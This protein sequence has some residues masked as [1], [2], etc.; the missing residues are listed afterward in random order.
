MPFVP[1]TVGLLPA[2]AAARSMA[3]ISRLRATFC[4]GLAMFR[5][6]RLLVLL[7]LLAFTAACDAGDGHDKVLGSVHVAAGQSPS[8]AST[9]NGAIRIDPNA[10]SG[11]DSTV[12]G[13][14]ELGDNASADTLSTVNGSIT[15]GAHASVQA[16][17]TV[18]GS[19][20]LGNGAR[21]T[22]DIES[23]NG[24]LSLS[25]GAD[26]AGRATNVN[27]HIS[28]D[29]AHVGGGIE[30]SNGDIDITGA[31]RVDG[32]ILVRKTNNNG[33]FHFGI[34]RTTH[35]VIGPGATVNGTLK[36]E[37]EVKLYV[38]DRAHVGPIVGA[39]PVKFS[40]DQP[41]ST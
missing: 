32:G 29:G 30:T 36:F 33:W 9:V 27:G 14:I 28:I 23:V 2:R 5:Y 12:N 24:G 1:V 7:P 26:V 41:P 10:K 15:L 37:R 20:R 38:S 17:S 13:S 3:S 21:I 25:Q 4:E 11:N 6:S 34:E 40:G 39:T 35:V 19:I 8:D 22:K 16:A 31:S 18:N